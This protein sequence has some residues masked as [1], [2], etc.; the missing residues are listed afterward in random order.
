MT[1]PFSDPEIAGS[2]PI[3]YTYRRT[4][5]GLTRYCALLGMNDPLCY[6]LKNY[7]RMSVLSGKWTG[8]DIETHDRGDYLEVHLR[9]EAIPTM[10]ANGFLLRKEL[11]DVL[12]VGDYLFDIDII[13]DLVMSGHST[14]AKVKTGIVHLYGSGLRTFSRKQLRRVR[15]FHY[16]SSR[17]MRSYPWSTRKKAGVLKFIVYCLLLVPLVYQSIKGYRRQPDTAWGLHLPACLITLA[18]YALGVIEGVVKP[19][20]QARTR[21]RQ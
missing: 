6:F 4:D 17:G 20:E 15:D 19:R 16:Y 18:V 11:L 7:D 1:A 8:L 12:Q 10:G 5:S 3:E 14:F 21:W 2:E 13:H 9:P